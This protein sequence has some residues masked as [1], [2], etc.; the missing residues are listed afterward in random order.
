MALQSSGAISLANVQTEFGGS[1]PTSISEYYGADAGVPASGTISLSDFYGTSS[2]T[3]SYLVGTGSIFTDFSVTTL[4]T[5]K[6]HAPSA[7]IGANPEGIQYFGAASDG[8]GNF[9]FVVYGDHAEHLNRQGF[10]EW[11]S[12]DQFQSPSFVSTDAGL[13]GTPWAYQPLNGWTVTTA[14]SASDAW[15]SLNFWSDPLTYDFG[16]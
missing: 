10:F 12:E 2:Y 8:S 11:F 14:S 7:V 13:G 4:G 16:G 9:Y 3:P 5:V 15:S 6:Y 1:A